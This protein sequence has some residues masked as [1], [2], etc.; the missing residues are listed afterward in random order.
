MSSKCAY[1]SLNRIKFQFFQNRLEFRVRK[2]I[3]FFKQ[4]HSFFNCTS[5]SKSLA[6]VLPRISLKSPAGISS[7][8][9]FNPYIFFSNTSPFWWRKWVQT[10]AKAKS[11]SGYLFF[12][13]ALWYPT[14]FPNLFAAFGSIPCKPLRPYYT[15]CPVQLV[16][17]NR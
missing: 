3:F 6:A 16:L 9:S 7:S 14:H 17:C 12:F 10:V 8:R 5:T 11:M 13:R 15:R 1:N 2:T 4:G